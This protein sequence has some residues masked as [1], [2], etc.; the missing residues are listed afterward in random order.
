MMVTKGMALAEDV[1]TYLQGRGINAK[2]G[3]SGEVAI[4]DPRSN[5]AIAVF[6]TTSGYWRDEHGNPATI[7]A[8][9]PLIPESESNPDTIGRGIIGALHNR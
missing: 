9:L 3:Y 1:A 4:L 8:I 5:E 6:E 2:G 7:I